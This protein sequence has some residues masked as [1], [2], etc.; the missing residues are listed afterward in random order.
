MK[1]I[2]GMN[3]LV[4]KVEKSVLKHDTEIYLES[5]ESDK[6]EEVFQEK[7]PSDV[8]IFDRTK[9][10]ECENIHELSGP[11]FKTEDSIL[12]LRNPETEVIK[13]YH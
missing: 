4:K 9:V 12:S 11:L 2:E 1:D 7:I 8:N 3:N 6:E 5:D 10:R 13:T